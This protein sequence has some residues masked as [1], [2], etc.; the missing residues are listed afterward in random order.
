MN[1]PRLMKLNLQSRIA[2]TLADLGSP[3]MIASSPTIEPGP[4]IVNIRS[5]P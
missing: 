5:S 4:R 1:A 3:S 2:T